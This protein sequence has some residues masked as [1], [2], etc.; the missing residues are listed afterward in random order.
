M[1]IESPDCVFFS[2]FTPLAPLLERPAKANWQFTRR[3]P[4]FI[5]PRRGLLQPLDQPA[6]RRE[7]RLRSELHVF[8]VPDFSF[9]LSRVTWKQTERKTEGEWKGLHVEKKKKTQLKLNL[10]SVTSS[11]GWTCISSYLSLWL[12]AVFI[13]FFFNIFSQLLN[14][15]EA[16]SLCRVWCLHMVTV[17]VIN[18]IRR[19]SAHHMDVLICRRASF[20]FCS[21]RVRT[22]IIPNRFCHSKLWNIS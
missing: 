18:Y 5:N 2:F 22:Q 20:F 11:K 21:G 7:K 13:L 12:S 10:W 17:G 1:S 9:W 4:N 19:S 8:F 6:N 15:C 3:S 14:E 16:F